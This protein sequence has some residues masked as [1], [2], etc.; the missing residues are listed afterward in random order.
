MN[1]NDL[2][3]DW[4]S[5]MEESIAEN[6][7]TI[8]RLFTVMRHRILVLNE[9]N[10]QLKVSVT[11]LE[12]LLKPDGV[13]NDDMSFESP[14]EFAEYQFYDGTKV[15]DSFTMKQYVLLPEVTYKLTSLSDDSFELEKITN[16]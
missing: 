1:M 2:L 13:C 9:E 11:K 15:G 8:E 4:L 6:D 7:I 5:A 16:D 12:E 10:K 14:Y 3:R